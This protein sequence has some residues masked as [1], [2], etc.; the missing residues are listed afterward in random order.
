M[1]LSYKL[2]I[3]IA[4]EPVK[5][6]I[7]WTRKKKLAKSIQI[8]MFCF[9]LVLSARREWNVFEFT[10]H[11]YC[12]W[13]YQGRKTAILNLK[14]TFII[15]SAFL[16][17]MVF[18]ALGSSISAY[19]LALVLNALYIKSIYVAPNVKFNLQKTACGIDHKLLFC[20][21]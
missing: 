16:F 9:W 11:F 3:N 12:H 20:S 8:V 2:C 7:K 5:V 17:L 21:K 15:F 4:L 1:I 18:Y 10:A 14:S 6:D 19:R 13:H